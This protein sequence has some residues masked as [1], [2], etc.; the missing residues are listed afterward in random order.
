MT[1]IIKGWVGTGVGVGVGVRVGVAVGAGVGVGD[2]GEAHAASAKT[3]K[4]RIKTAGG[5]MV[6]IIFHQWQSGLDY[7]RV[8]RKL[9]SLRWKPARIVA[10]RA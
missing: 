2:A 4:L 7:R 3:S 5:R 1:A 10:A 6:R 8:W 9:S